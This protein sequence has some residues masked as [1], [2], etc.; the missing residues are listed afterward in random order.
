MARLGQRKVISY[1]TTSATKI[2]NILA[3]NKFYNY[4]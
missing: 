1:V 4:C 2:K 3:A